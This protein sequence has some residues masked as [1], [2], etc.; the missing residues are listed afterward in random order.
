M[1]CFCNSTQFP[2]TKPFDSN[3]E[4]ENIALK[5]CK[6]P[7]VVISVYPRQDS[8]E[9][10]ERSSPGKIIRHQ[11]SPQN[12]TVSKTNESNTY[13]TKEE[14]KPKIER[15]LIDT[16]SKLA[17]SRSPSPASEIVKEKRKN[18]NTKV[19]GVGNSTKNQPSL[20]QKSPDKPVPKHSNIKQNVDNLGNYSKNVRQPGFGFKQQPGTSKEQVKKAL[21]NTFLKNVGKT[22]NNPA[23]K[24]IFAPKK[25]AIFAPKKDA[26]KITIDIN[27]E[28]ED[29]SVLLKQRH[30][31]TGLC[32]RK[33][34]KD[35]CQGVKKNEN[36]RKPLLISDSV[37]NDDKKY[38]KNTRNTNNTRVVLVG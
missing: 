32:I 5:Q 34:T 28:K 17:K 38:F 26:S 4:D 23:A 6:S 22:D 36:S 13:R 2:N 35:Q 14:K 21:V 24:K 3:V 18:T 8:V 10:V 7:L 30:F 20:R 1:Q 25:D 37:G 19:I 29:Y 15:T 33:R 27:G 16:K 9:I 11:V 31:D 12:M